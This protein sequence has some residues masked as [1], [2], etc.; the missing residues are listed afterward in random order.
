MGHNNTGINFDNIDTIIVDVNNPE[1]IVSMAKQTQIVINCVGP[2]S[3][4]LLL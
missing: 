1:S 4:K 3:M 2:V